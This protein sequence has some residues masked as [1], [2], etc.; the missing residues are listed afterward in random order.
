MKSE[1]V[2]VTVN[3]FFFPSV[4]RVVS[5]HLCVGVANA[6]E[7]THTRFTAGSTRFAYYER[8]RLVRKCIVEHLAMRMVAICLVIGDANTHTQS[9]SVSLLCSVS[10][11]IYMHTFAHLN[12]PTAVADD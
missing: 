1:R 3:S 12:T 4:P 5:R 11:T 6:V 10:I 2:V 7:R 8:P 9:P